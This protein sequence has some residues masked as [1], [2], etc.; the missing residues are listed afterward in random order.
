LNREGAWDAKKADPKSMLAQSRQDAKKGL[1][2]DH[3]LNDLD[4]LSFAPLRL[5]AR[6]ASSLLLI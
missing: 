1:N 3:L 5:S 2:H 6:Q 4:L